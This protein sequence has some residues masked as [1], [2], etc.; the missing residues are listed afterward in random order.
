MQKKAVDGYNDIGH[1]MDHFS[2]FHFLFALKQKAQAEVNDNLRH[3]FS[4][5]GRVQF[6]EAIKCNTHIIVTG[7]LDL[8]P[9]SDLP[10]LASGT[11]GKS[12]PHDYSIIFSE[13]PRLL[14]T[15]NGS[16]F[17]G[18]Q[19]ILDE[20]PGSCGVV[21]G[22]PRHPQSQGLI[23]R[24]NRT[25]EEKIASRAAEWREHG[26]APWYEWLPI[27]QCAYYMTC[28]VLMNISSVTLQRNWFALSGFQSK[29][30]FFFQ[31]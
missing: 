20:S 29:F 21:H 25:V 18:L 28:T 7:Q 16:E 19:T 10:S 15:D 9:Y 26:P 31:Y 12:E 2:K 17:N 4:V 13:I 27:I 24:R 6:F 14:H 8:L 5:M 11:T 3:I 23:E 1:L 22:R 30:Y